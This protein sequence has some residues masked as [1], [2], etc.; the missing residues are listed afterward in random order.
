MEEQRIIKFNNFLERE[1]YLEVY[2]TAKY[3]ISDGRN[4]FFTNFWWTKEIVQDSYPVLIHAINKQSELFHKLHQFI[5][6][7]TNLK[8][9]EESELM[10][11]YWTRHSYIPWHNDGSHYG[12][13]TIY[14]NDIWERDYGGYF[15]YEEQ[16]EIKAI[17]PERNLAVLQ[18]GGIN[19]CTTPVN[20]NGNMRITLQVFFQKEQ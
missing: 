12:G 16:D 10:I 11:Y 15:L 2:E 9:N 17:I 6:N 7:K 14:L 13:L 8:I 20:F 5:E 19:H 3:L 18:I 1:L 4:N